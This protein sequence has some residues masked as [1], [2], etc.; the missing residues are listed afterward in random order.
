MVHTKKKE[1]KR[2]CPKTSLTSYPSTQTQP[3]LAENDR[4]I[5][6]YLQEGIF[7]GIAPQYF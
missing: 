3:I 4:L 1:K 7:L 2:N 6:K 5:L